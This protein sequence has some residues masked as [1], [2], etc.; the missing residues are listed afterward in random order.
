MLLREVYAKNFGGKFK[1]QFES[2][3][4]T[5]AGLRIPIFEK[6]T[7]DVHKVSSMKKFCNILKITYIRKCS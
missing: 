1:D 5:I 2:I 4:T 6:L 7:P 3:L